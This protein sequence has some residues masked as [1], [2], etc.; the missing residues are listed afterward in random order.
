MFKGTHTKYLRD[1]WLVL[2]KS[3]LL[4]KSDLVAVVV[5]VVVVIA[6]VCS[7]TL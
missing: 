3:Y 2:R 6:P 7:H 4:P 1:F 5:K